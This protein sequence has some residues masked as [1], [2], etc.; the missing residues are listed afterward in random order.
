MI[1]IQFV[2]HILSHFILFTIFY[3]P[4]ITINIAEATKTIDNMSNILFLIYLLLLT[5]FNKNNKKYL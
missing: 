4:H 1:F 5:L 2:L 3:A